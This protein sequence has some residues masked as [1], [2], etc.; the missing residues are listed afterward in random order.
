[1]SLGFMES[2]FNVLFTVW[3]SF[4]VFLV[5]LNNN[6]IQT[7]RTGR[8]MQL[9]VRKLYEKKEAMLKGIVMW[10]KMGQH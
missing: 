2:W 8:S 3:D 10:S 4:I 9:L 7:V 1:M 5:S 6:H